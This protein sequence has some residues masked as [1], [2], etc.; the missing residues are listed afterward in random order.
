PFPSEVEVLDQLDVGEIAPPLDSLFGIEILQRVPNPRRVTYAIEG[1][2]LHF[3]P[4]ARDGDPQSRASVQA[5]AHM[6]GEELRRDPA[7]LEALSQRYEPLRDQW[8]DGR[9]LAQLSVALRAL[10]IG[11]WLPAPVAV[12]GLFVVGR[13]V[14][15]HDETPVAALLEL[16]ARSGG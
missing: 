1:L 10:A 3:D 12:A 2:Q 16:P 7:R 9:G 5:Q 11:E 4:A 15:A 13:R 6:L 14:A 8:L